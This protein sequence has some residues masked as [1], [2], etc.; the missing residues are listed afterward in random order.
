MHSTRESSSLTIAVIAMCGVPFPLCTDRSGAPVPSP[1]R[2]GPADPVSLTGRRPRRPARRRGARDRAVAHRRV[3]PPEPGPAPRR[4]PAQ[5]TADH[6]GQP[7]N[8]HR[9]SRCATPLRPDVPAARCRCSSGEKPSVSPGCGSRLSTTTTLA[10][11]AASAAR[12]CGHQQ[13]RQHGGVPGAR[14][15]ARRR[16]PRRSP[17]ARPGCTGGSGGETRIS[18]T[19]PGVAAMAT[20]PRMVRVRSGSSGST[21]STRATRSSG[22]SAIGS[23]RPQHAEQLG[24]RRRGRA[25]CRRRASRRARSAPGCR[26]GGRRA[27]RCRRGGAAAAAAISCGALSSRRPGRPAPCAGRPG[28]RT[29]ISRRMRPEEP[30]SSATVT[31]AVSVAAVS[32]RQAAEGRGQ[33]VA[34]AEARPPGAAGALRRRA[35]YSRPRSRCRAMAAMPSAASRRA[36]SSAMAT[37]R[38]LPPVQPTASVR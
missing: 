9:R 28:G 2:T 16:R 29:G 32:R 38:C 22:T 18:R 36:N 24:E 5:Q 31:T 1:F 34:A 37:L 3:R 13:V 4:T 23:T 12:S 21:L 30:P 26:P 17:R 6:G 10:C 14:A 33:P 35:H 15:R 20:C 25:R 11:V 19:R 27:R 8:Q 7:P